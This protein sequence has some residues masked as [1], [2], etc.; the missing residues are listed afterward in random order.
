MRTKVVIYSVAAVAS[1]ALFFYMRSDAVRIRRAFGEVAE[2]VSKESS[3]NIMES[4]ARARHVAAR[5]AE[6]CRCSVTGRDGWS[7]VSREHAA[8][9]VLTFRAGLNN[10]RVTFGDLKISS[11]DGAALVTGKALLDGAPSSTDFPLPRKMSFEAELKE[12]DGKW[13]FTR[14]KASE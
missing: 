12:V 11:A 9:A 13:L 7:T 8:G 5:L 14:I 6:P 4:M 1:L 10:L 2:V 3:E